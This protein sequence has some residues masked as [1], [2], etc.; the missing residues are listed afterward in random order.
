MSCNTKLRDVAD[1]QKGFAFKSKDYQ[2]TGVK[3]VKVS[4]LT[5]DSIDLSQCVCIDNELSKKY[6][7]K[8]ELM[9]G[10]IIITTVGSWPTNPASVVGKVIKVPTDANNT[11]LNQNAVR[12]R[13]NSNI[14]QRYLYYLLKN[15]TFKE[16]IVGTAQ[17]SANQ[18]SITQEDIK[19]FEFELHPL[20]EQEK[21]ANILSSLDDK[22][23]LNNEMNKTLEEMAQSIFKRWFVD[24]EFPNEDGEPYK[25]SGGEMVDSELGMIPKG[26]K[27]GTLDDIANITM[28][29]SPKSS[30]YNTENIGMP[31]LN[32]ASDFNGTIINPTKY[33]TEPKKI[34]KK[35]DMVFC[36]RATIGNLTFTDREYCIGRGVA[37]VT[38]IDTIYREFIYFNINTSIKSL[39]SKASGSVFLNLTKDNINKMDVVIPTS[40]ILNKF[41]LIVKN[42]VDKIS[43]NNLQ[44]Q[45]IAKL[46]DE[47]LPKLMSG[48]INLSK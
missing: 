1:F 20:E 25:S 34:C 27:Y 18:A 14:N 28:G 3:I 5:N 29:V 8:Y 23:E 41:S 7:D 11:L 4:N 12:V 13:S 35:D 31:L 37:S 36:I 15:E 46:R 33:T 16:Y 45:N 26:W 38:P 6:N 42:L 39:I 10:D 32:G 2:D 44:N 40:E 43:E 21:I 22:I 47:L 48:E 19:N 9:S 24:F 30:S 17:G